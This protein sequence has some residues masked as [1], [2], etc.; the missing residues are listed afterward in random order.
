MVG[1]H[2]YGKLCTSMRV[3]PSRGRGSQ[4]NGTSRSCTGIDDKVPQC[5]MQEWY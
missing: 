5:V 4:A 2:K 1:T 3:A